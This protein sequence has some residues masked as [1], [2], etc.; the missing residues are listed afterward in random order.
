MLRNIL[1]AFVVLLGMNG[2]GQT[3]EPFRF[4]EGKH[5][6]GELKYRNGVP[7]LVLA[8]TPEEMGEQMGVLGVKPA[9]Q[10]VRVFE[11]VLKEHRLDLIVPLLVKFGEAQLAKY[12]AEYRRE[13]EAMAR[14]SGID[15]ELL[16]IGNTFNELRHLAGCSGLMVAAN[17]SRT[18]GTLMGRN[19]DFPPVEGIHDCSLVIVYRPQGKHAF[20]V[21]S[22]PGAVATGCL[23]SGM[24][25][26]GL[27]IGGNFI[28]ESADGAPQVEWKNLPTAVIARRLLEECGTLAAAE[29][30]LRASKPTERH[31]LV[32][33]DRGGGA[34]FE[35][36][37][38]TIVVRR[39]KDG[40][41][42]GTN[43][44]LSRELSVPTVCGRLTALTQAA[45]LEKLGVSDVAK[46]MHE[47]NQ[48]A[49]TAHTLVFEP[50]P[51][52]LH[53]AF[54]DGTRSA[55]SFPLKEVKLR[56]LLKP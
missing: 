40:I 56:N 19:W 17:R 52:G 23:M 35:I 43:H 21:V 9:S 24:N 10:L 29:K 22:Y 49:W 26:E 37:S 18:G 12:P 38:R 42:V 41:C 45:R 2:W 8:G 15:R 11:K 1:L 6:K 53:I 44:F 36:T 5:G 4:P 55:T 51:L 14:A 16:L 54:G 13:F 20:A 27:T 7:V 33:C 28:G 50:G 46:K 39:D 25:A 31:S 47:A 48:G 34:V 30:L 32:A 3:A